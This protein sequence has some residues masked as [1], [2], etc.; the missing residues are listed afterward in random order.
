MGATMA[1]GEG[2]DEVRALAETVLDAAGVARLGLTVSYDDGVVLRHV[3]VSEAAAEILGY[4]ADELVGDPTE[5]AFGSDGRTRLEEL[6]LRW[7]GGDMTPVLFETEA[8]RKDGLHVPVEVALSAVTLTGEPAIVAFLRDIRERKAAEEA[9]RRS[10]NRFRQLIEAAPDAIGVV[11]D[12]RFIYVNPA[13]VRLLRRPFGAICGFAVSDFVHRDDREALD[14]RLDAIRAGAPPSV[15]HE[16]RVT[17]PDGRTIFVELMGLVVE[18]D[19]HPAV[20]EFAR[21]TT[22]RRQVQAQ[23]AFSDRMATLGMLAAGVA[24]EINNPL[25]YAM[26]N[27]NTLGRQIAATDGDSTSASLIASAIEGLGQVASIVRDLLGFSAPTS[28]D[29]WPV[30]AESVLESAINVAM[31]AIRGRARIVRRYG[32]APPLKTDPARLGQVLLNLLFNAAQSFETVDPET[33]TLTLE[34]A[35]PGPEQ[36][37]ITVADNGAG[38]SPRDLERIFEPFYTTKPKGTGLGLSMCQTLI[39]SLE[40]RIDVESTL[41]KGSTFVVW[42]PT[43]RSPG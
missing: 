39:A 10:E 6:L 32:P 3:Y 8:R 36:L 28:T 42:L 15:P 27:L 41:G 29:R 34:I 25:A 17:R 5:L 43:R 2:P 22:D 13:Y 1:G 40:G 7:R 14:R 4:Q 19:G 21:D 11:R 20:L 37:T 18:Y 9:L 26:L 35:S 12:R 23:L 31:H 16:V 30:E 33:N 24:H 38:I